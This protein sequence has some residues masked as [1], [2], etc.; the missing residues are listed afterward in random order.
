LAVRMAVHT[1]EAVERD[2]DYFG[3]TVN[4]A[5]RLMAIAHGGQIVVSATT[6]SL[7]DGSEL[8]DMG[9][10]RLRDLSRPE[11]VFQLCAAGL[12]P[13]F[14]PLRSLDTIPT[15]L[16]TELT[17]FVGRATELAEVGKAVR[18][19]RLVTITGVGGVGKTRLALQI[20]A[21][22]AVEHPDGA[23]LCELAGA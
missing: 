3:P 22:L 9:E 23:W 14:P 1:G 15:N 7:A 4:R 2:G 21:E 10:H 6:A 18:E 8:L 13:D 5:A 11:R 17:S 12:R 19:R 16:P 20:A